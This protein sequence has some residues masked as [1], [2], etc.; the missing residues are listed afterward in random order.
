MRQLALLFHYPKA[1][2]VEEFLAA[3]GTVRDAIAAVP[4]CLEVGMWREQGTDAIVAVSRWSSAEAFATGRQRLSA[5]DLP[6]AFSEWEYRDRVPAYLEEITVPSIAPK[7]PLCVVLYESADNLYETAPVHFP[8]HKARVD[9]FR[10]RGELLFVG[11]FG[12]PLREG[13]MAIFR[14]RA[15]AEEFVGDDP[16]VINGVVKSWQIRDW[17]ETFP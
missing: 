3:M 2:H 7:A 15:G 6:V 16:F 17:N 5:G 12:D 11:T 10:S 14:S 9:E 1:E 8:A 13:S 4:G